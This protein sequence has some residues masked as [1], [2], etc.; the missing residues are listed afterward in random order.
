VNVSCPDVA[1]VNE[2]PATVAL[3]CRPSAAGSRSILSVRTCVWYAMSL[4]AGLSVAVVP[5]GT[6]T[7]SWSATGGNVRRPL[8]MIVPA[9][10]MVWQTVPGQATVNPS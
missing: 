7:L 4:A 1:S 5:K 6:T 10:V 3:V 2:P 8:L 9:L